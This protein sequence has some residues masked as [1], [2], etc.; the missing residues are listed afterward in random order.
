MRA[1][2]LRRAP[3][4]LAE[5]LDALSWQALAGALD[6]RGSALLRGLLSASD[7]RALIEEYAR[8]ERFRSRIDMARH[9][10][11]RGEYQYFAYPLPPIVQQ[12]R[13]ALYAPL[14]EIANRW[15]Q[16]LRLPQRFP[17]Q[18]AQF[19]ARCHQAGQTRPTPLLLRYRAGDYNCLHQDL[20]GEHVFPL[21]LALLLS[22]PGADFQGGEFVLSEQRPRQ[23]SRVEV[24]ALQRGDAVVF[25]S[26]HR[27][28]RSARGHR[29]L[30]LRHGVSRLHAGERYTLGIV[31][32]D[33]R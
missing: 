14:A 26:R 1:S 30:T 17:P 33:A 22:A 8:P 19:L 16:A 28:E 9:R 31:F 5:R 25:A 27:P 13:S 20:Y 3:D 15:Q 21:Q 6:E 29:R 2:A 32:H 12:L 24:L 4:G 18:H 7:C 11:G 10:F 23:Q